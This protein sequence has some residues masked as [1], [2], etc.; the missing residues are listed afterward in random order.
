V[1]ITWRNVLTQAVKIMANQAFAESWIA[2]F[3]WSSQATAVQHDGSRRGGIGDLGQAIR[4]R[5]HQSLWIDRGLPG[6][7]S[8]GADGGTRTRTP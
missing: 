4:A 6:L 1:P 2:A 5:A 7:K 8:R 3:H